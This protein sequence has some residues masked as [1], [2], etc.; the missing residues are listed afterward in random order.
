[1]LIIGN[2][3]SGKSWL[4][5]KLGSNLSLPTYHL[6]NLHWEPDQPGVPRDK[7]VAFQDARTIATSPTWLIEGVFGWLAEAALDRATALVWIDLP[8][9]ECLKNIQTRGPQNG[10]N[11]TAFEALLAWTAD[12]EQRSTSTGYAAHRDLYT[13][14]SGAKFRLDHREAVSRF[15]DQPI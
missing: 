3:G 2:C 11:R 1:M 8:V 6:D 7:Q 4:A 9:P 12:Y 13:R 5:L 10:E 15:A 14:F